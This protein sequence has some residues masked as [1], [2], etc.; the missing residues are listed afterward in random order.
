[1]GCK[2]SKVTVRLMEAFMVRIETAS[3]FQFGEN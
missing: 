1:V 2:A 3:T